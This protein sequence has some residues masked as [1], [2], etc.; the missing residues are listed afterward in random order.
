MLAATWFGLLVESE[1]H[2]RPLGE[3]SF[4]MIKGS[5]IVKSF[6]NNKVLNNVDIE[7]GPG[8]ITALIGPSGGGKSTL[9][10][11]LSLLELPDSG[12]LIVDD[13]ENR[14][15]LCNGRQVQHSWPKLTVV[16]QQLFLWPHLTIRKNICLPVQNISENGSLDRIEE[17][18][19]VFDLCEFID[20]HPNQVSLGQRQRAAIVRALALQP[21]YLLLDEVTSAL[22]VEHISALLDYLKLVANNGCGILLATHLIGFAK[23]SASQ[24]LFMDK[25]EIIERGGAELIVTPNTDRLKGFLNLV[26]IAN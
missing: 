15:P 3:L 17:L 21:K 19:K 16:F 9:L 23:S 26:D 14:F 11:V 18:I 20:R 5:K 8:E 2:K 1:I 13:D 12:T 22:D 25:G 6:G 24:I 4:S 10:K 7:I